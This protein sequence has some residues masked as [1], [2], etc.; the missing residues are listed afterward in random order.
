MPQVKK[1]YPKSHYI[2]TMQLSLFSDEPKKQE[3][4]VRRTKK[5]LPQPTADI[6]EEKG[7]EKKKEKVKRG[8]HS[9]KEHAAVDT[10]M[11]PEDEVLFQ[12]QYYPI[13]KVAEWFNTTHSQIRLWEKEFDILKPKKNKKGDRYFRPED[14][15]NLKIIHYLL[16]QQKYSMEGA[17]LYLKEYHSK[18]Q[19]EIKLIECLTQ[20]K[21]FLLEIKAALE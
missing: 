1:C 18:V 3:K 5:L 7:L 8:R 12:K 19:K 9:L 6:I 13:A 21:T 2:Y 20:V 15:K 14:V 16:R 11:I 10:L 4:S 17:R